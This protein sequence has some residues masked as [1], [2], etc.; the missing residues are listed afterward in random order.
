MMAVAVGD[1]PDLANA[2]GRMVAFDREILPDPDWADRY[3]RMM[4]VYAGL[5]AAAQPFY[6]DL[7]AL[8]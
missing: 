5:H 4:P 6:A 8:A 2:V 3:D 7:D 1:A